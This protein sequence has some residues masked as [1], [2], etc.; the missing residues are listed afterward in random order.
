MALIESVII[1]DTLPDKDGKFGMGIEI[2]NNALV[3]MNSDYI[4]ENQSIGILASSSKIYLD[5][6]IIKSTKPEGSGT[7]GK[8]VE[9]QDG[10]FA[11]INSGYIADNTE[12]GIH[13][14]SSVLE[15]ESAG[16]S[17]TKQNLKSEFGRGIEI[18][19]NSAAGIFSC[20]ISGNTENGIFVD[21]SSLNLGSSQILNT[22]KDQN[23]FWGNGIVSQ[24]NSFLSLANNYICKN[25]ESGIKLDKSKASMDKNKISI[26]N[27]SK[28]FWAVNDLPQEIPG[29]VADGIAVIDSMEDVTIT[30]NLIEFCERAGVIFDH[31]SGKFIDN[32]IANN[33]IGYVSQFSKIETSGTK[34][35]NNVLDMN[36]DPVSPLPVDN[37]EK[38]LPQIAK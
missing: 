20:S 18:D 15:L 19:E 5:R 9:I 6:S 35:I 2:N 24:N 23:G 4:T 12:V 26:V 16:I 3:Q 37:V 1:N 32:M 8:G 29:P 34:F 11:E 31:S 36:I 28:G 7:G 14:I 13:V 17:G 22:K 10:S 27:N 30:S 33:P 38:P 21:S 25:F